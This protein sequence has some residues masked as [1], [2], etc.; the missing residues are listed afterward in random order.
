MLRIASN[1]VLFEIL[2]FHQLLIRLRMWFHIHRILNK[3]KLVNCTS[4][5]L[6]VLAGS[7]RRGHLVVVTTKRAL[8]WNRSFRLHK[9]RWI[10]LVCSE[11]LLGWVA[12][13]RA[14]RLATVDTC[15][16]HA[17]LRRHRHEAASLHQVTSRL[18]IQPLVASR[19]ILHGHRA[20]LLVRGWPR[21]T[22]VLLEQWV[23]TLLVIDTAI[24][25]VLS[26]VSGLDI[27]EET[28]V[29]GQQ[30]VAALS[31]QH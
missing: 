27:G 1:A 15:R 30:L 23:M 8:G 10:H 5:F 26:I 9:V 31:S 2:R 17:L 13:S 7:G 28:I 18:P 3:F 19:H 21:C 20:R 11:H 22:M 14:D 29:S 6:H 25:V 12:Q 24:N 4:L 16:S